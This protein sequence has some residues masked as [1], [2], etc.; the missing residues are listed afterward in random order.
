MIGGFKRKKIN[1]ES[2]GANPGG[3]GD[4]DVPTVG[5]NTQA[6]LLGVDH[7]CTSL[8]TPQVLWGK[9]RGTCTPFPRVGS[10]E[11]SS[12]PPRHGSLPLYVSLFLKFSSSS[13]PLSWAALNL[14]CCVVC[15]VVESEG[16]FSLQC[17]GFSLR[18]LLSLRAHASFSSCSTWASAVHGSVKPGTTV[19]LQ[20]SR[21]PPSRLHSPHVLC[22]RGLQ[23]RLAPPL[24]TL[25]PTRR[26][27]ISAPTQTGS[28]PP[29]HPAEK[30]RNLLLGDVI[31]PGCKWGGNFPS[32]H[33]SLW[34]PDKGVHRSSPWARLPSVFSPP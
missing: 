34:A 24:S 13:L 21:L 7:V 4:G 17:T 2:E 16:Y 20:P 1:D 32:I 31:T 23:T 8:A 26:S 3:G 30:K 14:C 28:L 15:L 6:V 19:G 29:P 12:A 22:L 27:V 9:E 25:D 5:E 11:N 18:W 33:Y 10:L